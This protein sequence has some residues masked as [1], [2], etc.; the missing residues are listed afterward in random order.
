MPPPALRIRAFD[1]L[2]GLAVF[3]MVETH[4]LV[5]LRPELREGPWGGRLG[6]VNGLVAPSFIFASG[7]SLALVQVRAATSTT[8]GLSRALRLRRSLRRIC[9][10][11][12]VGALVNFIWFHQLRWLLRLDILP[13]I[14]VSLMLALPLIALLAKYPRALMAAL[15]LLATGTFAAAPLGE[16]VTGPWANLVNRSGSL[17]PVFPLLPWAGYVFLGA[18]V[19]A[20]AAS[21]TLAVMKRSLLVLCAVT[22]VLW[23]MEPWFARVYPPHA[24]YVTD[25]A[26]HANRLVF[27]IALLLL[28]LVAEERLPPGFRIAP[29]MRL[30]E[31][32]GTT[33]LAAYF[34]HEQL[35]FFQG[36][37]YS[38]GGQGALH[39]FRD[40]CGW[41]QFFLLLVGVWAVTA[42]LVK[43][44]DL[45]Y[46]YWEKLLATCGTALRARA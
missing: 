45:A 9:E 22:A 26:N 1:W 12:G 30:I 40:R 18:A 34:F 11:I 8:P 5:F 13:C 46:P 36:G 6:L 15:L 27:V 16:Q 39:S 14:G 37:N 19:G 28:L 10:V 35:L 44:A 25:P 41:G 38:L 2:R 3:V 17:A 33:S 20:L 29:P 4:S 32:F 7:F 42:V 24:Y 21:S 43:A 23:R 31:L